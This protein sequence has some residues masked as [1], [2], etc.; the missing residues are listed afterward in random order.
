[1]GVP[2]FSE[3]IP[4]QI[5]TITT[6]ISGG[7]GDVARIQAIVT[8]ILPSA[9]ETV[10]G[11]LSGPRSVDAFQGESVLDDLKANPS[12]DILSTIRAGIDAR[13]IE[14]WNR[15]VAGTVKHTATGE[16]WHF[17]NT[18]DDLEFRDVVFQAIALIAQGFTDFFSARTELFIQSSPTLEP[19]L[20]LNSPFVA[21][22]PRCVA[23]VDDVLSAIQP[24]LPGGP[25][26][27]I[28]A[29]GL[30]GSVGPIGPTGPIGFTGLPGTFPTSGTT[31]AKLA[32]K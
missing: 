6:G 2:G 7:F 31:F 21:A 25:V 14:V 8:L 19:C 17:A 22:D 11:L 12:G 27:P 1:L 26:G 24:F 10:Q 4:V 9:E 23:L 20:T 15:I 29:T 30:P 28:G 13:L 5:G 18:V 3:G 16:L 32:P